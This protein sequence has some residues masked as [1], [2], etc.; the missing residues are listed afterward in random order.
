[1]DDSA[2]APPLP[3]GDS[4]P[5]G[6]APEPG[7]APALQRVVAQTLIE[8]RTTLGNG[9]QLLLQ[10]AFPVLLLIFLTAVPVLD[11]GPGPRVAFLAPGVIALGVMSSAFTGQAIATGFERRYGVLKRLG[12]T[13]LGRPGLLLAKTA[14][15]ILTEV[16]QVVVLSAIAVAMGWRPHG[17]PVVA[18]LLVLIG[19]AGF[20]GLGLLL[21]GTLRAEATLAAA[22]LIYLVLLGL[23]GV[24][25]PLRLLPGWLQ[26]VSSALPITALSQGL[27]DTLER[28]ATLPSHALIVLLVWTVIG[29]GAAS[30]TFRWE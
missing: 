11:L 29:L 6:F 30:L 15:V 9:E 24:F 27:R 25:Y 5:G 19:T 13:P 28:G 10:L 16:L 18:L 3:L 21:A 23:G 20:S 2:G 8:L 4:R 7:A 1:V 14:T 26:A 17:A 12:A 22:N